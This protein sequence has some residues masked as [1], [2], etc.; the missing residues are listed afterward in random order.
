MVSANKP[1]VLIFVDWYY[2]GFRA[3]GPIRS[4]W[5]M[6]NALQ[7][8]VDFFVI[9][10]NTDY[11]SDVPYANV[12]PDQ[13]I[14]VANGHQVWY[15]SAGKTSANDFSTAIG[16]IG[17]V[18]V[19]YIN[20]IFS[21]AFSIQPARMVKKGTLQ[22]KKYIIAPRGMFAPD[23]LRIKGIKKRLFLT[24]A[25]LT[26][27][28]KP[29]LWHVTNQQEA[30]QVKKIF[31]SAGCFVIPNL[32]DRSNIIAQ[33]KIEK[34]PG[35]LW[36]ASVARIA[37]EKN[38]L[39]VLE[40]LTELS[41]S[42]IHLDVYGSTYSQAYFEQCQAVCQRLPEGITVAFCGETANET[43]IDTLQ[44]Y[45]A[46]ILPTLGENFGHIIA[47]SLMANV[48]VIISNRT[49][50]NDVHQAKAGWVLAL[51]D[52]TAWLQT[53]QLLATM[54]EENYRLLCNNAYGYIMEKTQQEEERVKYLEM[55]GNV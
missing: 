47:E 2:P 16:Q 25:K 8:S 42:E 52:K 49:P 18:D 11:M 38:L 44:P 1:K 15:C 45:H 32:I 31:G 27:L 48:P 29:F 17:P 39:Y 20:G 24:L 14:T 51:E 28:Y 36:L 9:T 46:L 3:G 30:E 21:P 13:W 54:P 35:K 5:N 26:G 4:M 22:A 6:M 43:L 37:P 55:F 41:G 23:A 50:W 33:R 19:V 53:F 12:A 40:R 34:L 10:R 7:A